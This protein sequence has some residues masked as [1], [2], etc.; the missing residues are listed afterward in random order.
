M[1]LLLQTSTLQ[2]SMRKKR[3]KEECSRSI[4]GFAVHKIFPTMKMRREIFFYYSSSIKLHH[5]ELSISKQKKK[6][7]FTVKNITAS[8]I[9]IFWFYLFQWFF[10]SLFHCHG[11]SFTIPLQTNREIIE[12]AMQLIDDKHD[13]IIHFRSL[14]VDIFT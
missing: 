7:F 11:L 10:F 9:F 8:R 13:V 12:I 6:T 2:I 4:F 14:T 5:Y 1:H 3:L